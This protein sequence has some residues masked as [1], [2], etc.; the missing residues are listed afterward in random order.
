MCAIPPSPRARWKVRQGPWTGQRRPGPLGD[1]GVD[2]LD[3]RDQVGRVERVPDDE[4]GRIGR[5]RRHLAQRE[6]RG[7]GGDHH[8]LAGR[9]HEVGEERALELEIL[10]RALLDEPGPVAGLRHRSRHPQP[11]PVGAVVETRLHQGRPGRVDGAPQRRLGVG[12]RIPR[13]DVEP[14]GQ[15]VRGPPAADHAGADARDVAG[16]GVLSPKIRL[17]RGS[18]GAD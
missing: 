13:H 4:A 14:A 11:R 1:R 5:R 10:R 16:H 7:G 18:Q 8:V 12:S 17:L 2:L 3:Q 15:E 9:G 6:A